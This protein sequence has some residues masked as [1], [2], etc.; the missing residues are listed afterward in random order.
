MNQR[1]KQKK[2]YDLR[3]LIY[4]LI[5]K[6]PEFFQNLKFL[7]Q[8]TVFLKITINRPSSLISAFW[9]LFFSSQPA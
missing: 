2:N 3:R 7:F 5:A 9:S 4:D 6:N 1:L 8:K